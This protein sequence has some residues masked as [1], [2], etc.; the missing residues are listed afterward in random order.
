MAIS[1]KRFKLYEHKLING[2]SQINKATT[3]KRQVEVRKY[4]LQILI[5]FSN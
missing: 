4:T 2:K 5:F 3:G 1:L